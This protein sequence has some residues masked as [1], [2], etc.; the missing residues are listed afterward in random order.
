MYQF[1]VMGEPVGKARPRVTRWGAYTPQKT[2][3]Y[4]NKIKAAYGGRFYE[5]YLQMDVK[6]YFKIP[7]S[8]SKKK[9][10]SM[11]MGEIKPDKKPDIDNVLKIV[12]DSLNKTA[13]KDDAQVIAASITKEYS[14]APRIKITISELEKSVEKKQI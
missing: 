3:D 13:Y 2:V 10:E 12:L 7:K 11:L 5:G 6:A 14:D 9:K 8:T 1:E 4:E